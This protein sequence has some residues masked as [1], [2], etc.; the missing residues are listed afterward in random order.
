MGEL[1]L[2]RRYTVPVPT[3]PGLKVPDQAHALLR[4]RV[5]FGPGL[6]SKPCV[7]R[8]RVHIDDS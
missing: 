6:A 4:L 5:S 1:C 2:Y 3:D 8:G 7:L